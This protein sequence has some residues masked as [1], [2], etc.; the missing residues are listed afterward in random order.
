LRENL[1]N[2]TKIKLHTIVMDAYNM[3]IFKYFTS[4]AVEKL[5][6]SLF[7]RKKLLAYSRP[8]VTAYVEDNI[9]D[10]ELVRR[11][12]TAYQKNNNPELGESMWK[13]FFDVRHSGT[14]QTFIDGDVKAVTQILRDPKSSDLFYG[15]DI[16]T[17]S[18]NSIFKSL[19]N[20][21]DY[22]EV[23]FDGLVRFAEASGSITIDNPE[24]WPKIIRRPLDV[25]NV[26]EEINKS[27][28]DFSVPTPYP[29]EYG[30]ETSKGVMSYRVPQALYQA[31][32]IK[33]LVKDIK[34]PRILEIGAGLGRT[35][36]YANELGL[37][38]YTI[39]DIPI[40][41]ASQAYFLGRTLGESVVRLDGETSD[42]SIGKVKIL[43]P[44][45]FMGEFKSYDLILNADS[46]T[47][48]DIATAKGYWKKIKSST[49]IFLSINHEV[50]SYSVKDL[51]ANDLSDY[52]VSRH[53]S[54]MRKGYVEEL[55]VKK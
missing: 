16:L 14:H 43:S 36:Y 2:K 6:I 55:V 33:Q 20:R 51:I 3:G 15:F 22:A 13:L 31:W 29:D 53:P 52:D 28:W 42:G 24:R 35:A 54:W 39:V 9:Q 1:L 21:K 23:C 40:T 4:S 49:K 8:A 5:S 37:K 18:F 44:A 41:A 38:D 25:E 46:L 32:R 10:L 34:N 17:K 7:H 26:I 47:E 48:L 19:R 12:I 50:N 11:I 45:T 30:L 27:C